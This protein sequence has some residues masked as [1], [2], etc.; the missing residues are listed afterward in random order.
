MGIIELINKVYS[1]APTGG[2]CHIVLDDGNVSD[3]DINWCLDNQL[4]N[5]KDSPSTPEELKIERYCLEELLSYPD[6]ERI[7]IIETAHKHQSLGLLAESLTIKKQP[8][9]R[10]INVYYTE[11][12]KE[13]IFKTDIED[14]DTHKM[15]VTEDGTVVTF[16]EY[17]KPKEWISGKYK[18]IAGVINPGKIA[19][20][21]KK[22]NPKLDRS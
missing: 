11:Y 5:D 16:V 4:E 21:F 6:Y 10:Y 20:D 1:F 8:K 3:D 19:E 13:Y 14:V 22:N 15:L 18:W 9:T 12:G 7:E 2:N 17:T